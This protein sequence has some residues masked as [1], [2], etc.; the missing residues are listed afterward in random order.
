MT[1]SGSFEFEPENTKELT[2][3]QWALAIIVA[4]ESGRGLTIKARG[5]LKAFLKQSLSNRAELLRILEEEGYGKI[6]GLN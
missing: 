5:E 1:S 4:Y 2:C 6:F 3:K